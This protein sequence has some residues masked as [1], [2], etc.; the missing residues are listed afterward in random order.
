MYRPVQHQQGNSSVRTMLFSDKNFNTLQNV[1]VQDFQQRNGVPLN[2]QQ[3]ERLNKTLNHYL[4]QVYQVQGEKPVQSLNKEVLS[5]CAKDFSQYLQRK[6][7]TKN[8]TPVKTVMDES[9]FQETSQRFEKL[10]QER[11]EVK[12]LP[13]PMPDFRVEFKEDGPPAAELY[14]RAKKQRE[15]EALRSAQQ[16]TELLRAEAG[17]Q[18]RVAADSM[19]RNQQDVQ[20][21]NTELALVQRQQIINRPLPTQDLS[22]AIMPDRRD[23]L[24]AP[25]GSFDTMTQSPLPRELGQAN[26]NPTIVQPLVASPEKNNLPQ[27]YIQREDKIVSYREIENNLFIYSDILLD[28]PS[29]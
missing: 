18:S 28:Y 25:I 9:L 3:I 6:E 12:A 20:N 29:N 4:T 2:E 14:E 1:L 17:L 16:N 8:T 24:L 13:P 27:N 10:T 26:A 11:H 7:L 15:F 22:L 21:Q 19:F 23:L 5:A